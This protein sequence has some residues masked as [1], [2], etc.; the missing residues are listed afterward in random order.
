M[1]IPLLGLL[2]ITAG[3]LANEHSLEAFKDNPQ[4]DYYKK[5]Y[6]L[7]KKGCTIYTDIAQGSPVPLEQ[8]IELNT[9]YSS[10]INQEFSK[11]STVSESD[12]SQ[13]AENIAQYF[14]GME[15]ALSDYPLEDILKQNNTPK[16]LAD[17]LRLEV[18]T[19]R[20]ISSSIKNVLIDGDLEKLNTFG[21]PFNRQDQPSQKE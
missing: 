9:E 2:L 14:A 15:Q 1:K 11:L 4:N 10:F 18:K 7:F 17:Q 19:N 12:Y 21:I 13:C 20:S 6:D 16:E 8:Q 5:A 3:V